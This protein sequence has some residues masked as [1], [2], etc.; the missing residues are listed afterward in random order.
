MLR[1]VNNEKVADEDM[2]AAN[3]MF[4]DKIGVYNQK[5]ADDVLM[6]NVDEE[7]VFN[8][9]KAKQLLS[10]RNTPKKEE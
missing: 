2:T 6:M 7:E 5:L 1:K 8:F 4:T 9:F 3:G 10:Q